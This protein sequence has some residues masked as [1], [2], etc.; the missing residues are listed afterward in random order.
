MVLEYRYFV[1]KVSDMHKYLDDDQI[2]EL[3]A[4]SNI[5]NERRKMDGKPPL[6]GVMVEE[7]WPEY[8]PTVDAIAAR[9]GENGTAVGG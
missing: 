1:L 2:D 8:Q 5:V 9:V 3:T 4:L 7:D 6:M